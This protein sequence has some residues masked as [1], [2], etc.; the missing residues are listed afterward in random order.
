MCRKCGSITP[1]EERPNVT[2]GPF[3]G[4]HVDYGEG[5]SYRCFECEAEYSTREEGETDT[6]PK[7]TNL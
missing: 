1:L 5:K 2:V 7:S 6:Q 3:D 4:S